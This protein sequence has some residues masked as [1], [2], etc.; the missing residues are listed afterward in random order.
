MEIFGRFLV[1]VAGVWPR[2]L[3]GGTE[4]PAQPLRVGATGQDFRSAVPS[5]RGG[6]AGRV[7][8]QGGVRRAVQERA[9]RLLRGGDAE[10]AAAISDRAGMGNGV[11]KTFCFYSAFL[12]RT[13]FTNKSC[14]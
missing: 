7:R 4:V 1:K 8:P 14:N 6:G 12:I 5:Q 13:N 10:V 2:R 3:P 11:K 9:R